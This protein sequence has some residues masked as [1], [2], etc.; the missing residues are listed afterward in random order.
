MPVAQVE[1]HL[2][3]LQVRKSVWQGKCVPNKVSS[4]FWGPCQDQGG[5]SVLPAGVAIMGCH[6]LGGFHSTLLFLTVSES[7][8]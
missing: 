7:G 8:V 3:P 4:S 2:G 1:A 5:L 6:G